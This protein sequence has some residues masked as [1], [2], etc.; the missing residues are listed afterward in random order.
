VPPNLG[1]TQHPAKPILILR[2][3]SLAALSELMDNLLL[4]VCT[5]SA[6]TAQIGIN[7]GKQK[8]ILGVNPISAEAGT[9]VADAQGTRL[10]RRRK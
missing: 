3:S 7:D 9:G 6:P 5:E 1:G 4:P 10:A 2:F 8:D